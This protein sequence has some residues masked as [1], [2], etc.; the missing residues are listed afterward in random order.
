M[1]P[2][3]FAGVCSPTR[4][5]TPGWTIWRDGFCHHNT[6]YAEL[7]QQGPNGLSAVR[8]LPNPT[9]CQALSSPP[10]CPC[11]WPALETRTVHAFLSGSHNQLKTKHFF[12]LPVQSGP[13]IAL[14]SKTQQEKGTGTGAVNT[15]AQPQAFAS[16]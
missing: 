13:T 8:R 1:H 14:S 6:S 3:T 11:S 4:M 12:L 10:R 15:S 7:L 16:L 5:Q 9:R 2:S